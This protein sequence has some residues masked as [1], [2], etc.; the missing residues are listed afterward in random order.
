MTAHPRS[1]TRAMQDAAT[2][3]MTRQINAICSASDGWAVA[4][5]VDALAP[6]LGRN[7]ADA[8]RCIRAAYDTDD[9]DEKRAAAV[10]L[11]E[12]ANEIWR[13]A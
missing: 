5:L 13:N 8:L 9:Q 3:A 1:I 11:G 4:A 6:R 7:E 10:E 2:A 12:A